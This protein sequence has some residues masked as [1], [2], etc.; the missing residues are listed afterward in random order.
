MRDISFV[1]RA[2]NEER[3]VGHAIQSV[4]DIFGN[5]TQINVVYHQSTDDTLDVIKLFGKSFYNINVLSIDEKIYR[6]GL[7]LNHGIS[8]CNTDVVGIL[9]S[10]CEIIAADK[11]KILKY[12]DDDKCF[13]VMG[14]QIPI[15]RGKKI[16]PRYIWKNFAESTV[17]KNILEDDGDTKRPFFHNAF[18]FIK[19]Q[20]IWFENK[21]NETL[22]GKED[23]YW[24]KDLCDMGLYFWFDPD[25]KCQ[26]H[27]T[28][29][30]AT[31][32]GIG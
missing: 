6:P 25:I 23:R 19:K 4:L 24:A 5:K 7:A 20:P 9:S 21:F 22:S 12:F 10:H 29:A 26:H 30:G 8:F 16:T 28:P 14:K 17:K 15:Y 2:H 11:E 3:W 13:G 31:W 27:W 18:S 32:S 1:I